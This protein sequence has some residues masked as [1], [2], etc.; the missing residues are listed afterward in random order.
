MEAVRVLYDRECEF[1]ALGI[2]SRLCDHVMS[3]QS[4]YA[5]R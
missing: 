5:T 4:P 3:R 1:F 2:I